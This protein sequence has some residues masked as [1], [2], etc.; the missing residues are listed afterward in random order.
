M[1]MSPTDF[2][3]STGMPLPF[4]RNCLP[5]SV[6]SGIL[7]RVERRR[8]HGDR[9]ARED[10]G[11]VA[12]EQL[13]RLDRQEDVEVP[14]RPATQP[15]LT[16]ASEADAR[17]ILHTLRDVDR[18]RPL[19][20]D[21]AGSRAVL[22][23]VLNGFSPALAIGTGPLDGEEAL[24]RAHLAVA[25][26]GRTGGRPRAGFGSGTAALLAGDAGR[27][28]D[29]RRLAGVGLRQR[30][31]EVVAQIRAALAPRA[32][33]RSAPAAHELAEEIVEDVR[34]RRGEVRAEPAGSPTGP[35]EC[36]VTELVVGGTLLRVL[37]DLIGLGDFLEALLGPGI[38]RIAV[39][40]ALL[41]QLAKSRFK[42]LL[43]GLPRQSE[44][45]VIVAP[46][47]LTDTRSTPARKDQAY[48][49]TPAQQPQHRL[50]VRC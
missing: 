33:A 50:A 49:S 31:L 37:Q 43:A 26:A 47:H 41:G 48:C 6:P 5:V 12:L 22:A 30:D 3:R 46:G 20:R 23:R 27:H 42:V 1:Y 7:I 32:G 17:T 10:V 15:R 14:G 38:A 29:L 16:F 19:P 24:G 13:M 34:H 36:R 21:A 45:F 25:G 11:A 8:H 35:L 44:D 2:D 9:N 18:Q 40:M 39:R 4:S 28:T